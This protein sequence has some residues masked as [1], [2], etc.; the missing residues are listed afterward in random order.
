MNTGRVLKPALATSGD[1]K[2]RSNPVAPS[3]NPR[4]TLPDTPKTGKSGCPNDALGARRIN[5]T[6]EIGVCRFGSS[7]NV[8]MR[9][10]VFLSSSPKAST[11][12][13]P[14]GSR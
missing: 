2:I 1:R 8:L 9:S 13:P 5:Q 6:G 4:L 12:A 7:A 3:Q 10:Q 11:L 14:T